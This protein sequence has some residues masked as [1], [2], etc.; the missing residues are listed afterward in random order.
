MTPKDQAFDDWFFSNH[1]SVIGSLNENSKNVYYR[2]GPSIYTAKKAIWDAAIA[3]S[4]G[5]K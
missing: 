2:L 4:E 1:G 5:S 3:W